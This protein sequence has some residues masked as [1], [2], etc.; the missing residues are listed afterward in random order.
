MAFRFESYDELPSTSDFCVARAKAG[1]PAGLA[2]MAGRQIAGRGSRGR[3]WVSAAGNLA[4]SVL[5]RPVTPVP[6]AGVYALLAGIAVAAAVEPYGVVPLLKWP[7]DVLLDGAKLAGI[8]IDAAPLDRRLDWLV[9]G[10]GVN[11]AYAPEIAGRRTVALSRYVTPPE[12]AELAVA[13]LEQLSV[14]L[15]ILAVSGVAAIRDGWLGRAHPVG[16]DL[17]ISG[18]SGIFVGLSEAGELLL[19]VEDRIERFQTGEILLGS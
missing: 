18:T 8:L 10:I 14:W 19:E 15:E 6:E 2:V 3:E 11:L 17:T 7:N 5:L 12:P 4:L 9:I 13:V 16:T 1:E